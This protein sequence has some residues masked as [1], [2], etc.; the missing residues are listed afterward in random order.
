MARGSKWL[1]LQLKDDQRMESR[2][3]ILHTHFSIYSHL[4]EQGFEVVC[5]EASNYERNEPNAVIYICTDHEGFF[6]SCCQYYAH[7]FDISRMNPDFNPP[8]HYRPMLGKKRTAAQLA[9]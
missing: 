3:I 6:N 7:D 8:S 9:S 1:K 2:Y 4:L 5:Y